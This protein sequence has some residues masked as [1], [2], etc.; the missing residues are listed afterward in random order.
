MNSSKTLERLYKLREE[1]LR[2][3]KLI[4]ILILHKETLD[5]KMGIIVDEVKGI[6]KELKLYANESCIETLERIMS[7]EKTNS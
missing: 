4:K 2:I 3:H 1:S 5:Y 6:Q 7:N